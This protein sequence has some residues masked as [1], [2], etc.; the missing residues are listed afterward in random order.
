MGLKTGQLCTWC[1]G[2]WYMFVLGCTCTC[3]HIAVMI[4]WQMLS[5]LDFKAGHLTGLWVWSSSWGM[6]LQCTHFWQILNKYQTKFSVA[7]FATAG[8]QND[9]ARSK[10]WK[11]IFHPLPYSLTNWI[12]VLSPFL[13][14][15]L[16]QL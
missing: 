9:T 13:T 12:T 4:K 7:Y 8:W 10:E 16:C 14:R 15:P 1:T 3:A 6:R 2:I 5:V 11:I